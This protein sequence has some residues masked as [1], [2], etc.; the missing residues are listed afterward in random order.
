MG[1]GKR[2]R[3]SDIHSIEEKYRIDRTFFHKDLSCISKVTTNS[4]II[5][6]DA[7]KSPFIR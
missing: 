6:S 1:I 5:L 7:Q 2:R 3:K 4:L